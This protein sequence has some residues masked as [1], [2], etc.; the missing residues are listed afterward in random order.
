M[1]FPVGMNSLTKTAIGELKCPNSNATPASNVPTRR[2]RIQLQRAPASL[3]HAIAPRRPYR[4]QST[5]TYGLG[6]SG[7]TNPAR[8]F[9]TRLPV[10]LRP[11]SNYSA[12]VSPF[13]L[14]ANQAVS[15]PFGGI[16]GEHAKLWGGVGCWDEMD[17]E[18]GF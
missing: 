2:P 5:R 14:Q 12:I 8:R 1:C 4:S 11:R 18:A 9:W 15:S 6:G 7:G 13:I 10:V 17:I 3:L 16:P